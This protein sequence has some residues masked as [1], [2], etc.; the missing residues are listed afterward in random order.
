VKNLELK[1]H[2]SD[3]ILFVEVRGSLVK[4]VGRDFADSLSNLLNDV[5]PDSF[6]M[7]AIDVRFVFETDAE[8][9]R[10]I[11]TAY[12]KLK[13]LDKG[14]ILI[15]Q[16]S[17]VKK[18][19]MS[20]GVGVKIVGSP[21]EASALVA[22]LEVK[23]KIVIPKLDAQ[24]L[25]PFIDGALKTLKIQC[26]LEATPG[27]P[28]LKAVDAT[29]DIA[30]AGVIGLTSEHFTGTISI[31]FSKSLFL[32]LMSNMLGEQFTEINQD[33]E[34]GAGELLNII[35]GQAKIV[36]NEKGYAIQK[37]L[38]TVVRGEKLMVRHMTP[39]PVIIIPFTTSSGPMFIEV[40]VE[41]SAKQAA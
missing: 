1:Q 7:L 5:Q 11:T 10:A 14:T 15:T 4:E 23:A 29:Y 27:K 18:S 35:F 13:K 24:F 30:I 17:L 22:K 6:A 16:N 8:F 21:Q 20:Q 3:G 31:G 38:P 36:L 12:M 37:A 40:G 26:S 2:T 39:A 34:D 33:L 9:I 32:N 28:S 25:N 41:V 19:I